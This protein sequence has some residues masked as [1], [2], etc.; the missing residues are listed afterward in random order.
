MGFFPVLKGVRLLIWFA[1]QKQSG[2]KSNQQFLE[3]M[4]T[5]GKGNE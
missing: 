3:P 4:A 2:K 5:A 1:E